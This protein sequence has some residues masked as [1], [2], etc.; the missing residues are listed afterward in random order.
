MKIILNN[1]EEFIDRD[2]ITVSEL[3]KLRNFTFKMIV[4]KVN[5]TLIRKPDYNSTHI[6]DGDVVMMLHLVSGG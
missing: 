5:G 3:L 2:S 4:V 6:F 1:T